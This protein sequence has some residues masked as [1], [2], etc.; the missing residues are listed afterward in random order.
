M[1]NIKLAFVDFWG[2][3]NFTR[4]FFYFALGKFGNVEIVSPSRMP[5][6]ILTLPGTYYGSRKTVIFPLY[7]KNPFSGSS[8]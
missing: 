5:V 7:G 4:N 6:S 8:A 1:K 2:G 3:F